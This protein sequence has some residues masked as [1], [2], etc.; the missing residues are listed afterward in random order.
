MITV[1]LF[2]EVDQQAI[3]SPCGTY[4]YLLRRDWDDGRC[5]AWLMLNPSTADATKNDPTI[6][7]CIEFSKRWGYARLIVVNLFALR[8]TDP[9]QLARNTDPVGPENDFYLKMAF[10]ESREVVCAWGC[11]QHLTNPLLKERPRK[12]TKLIPKFH[13]AVCLGFRKDGSPRHPLM[14]PY[15]QERL[16]YTVS[17]VQ[18]SLETQ[19]AS[20]DDLAVPASTQVSS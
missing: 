15:S 4:R 8:S 18:S 11:Q 6:R 14:V 20:S 17:P 2:D 16:P 1:T 5:I 10:E 7:R 19:P 13:P 12:A 9:R 3:F